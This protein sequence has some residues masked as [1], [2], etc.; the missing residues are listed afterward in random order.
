[1]EERL[2]LE[3]QRLFVNTCWVMLRDPDAIPVPSH[4]TA[5]CS[6]ERL[7]HR[8]GVKGHIVWEDSIV[9]CQ[10]ERVEVGR[11]VNA[12]SAQE[13]TCLGGGGIQAV[14]IHETLAGTLW[15]TACDPNSA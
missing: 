10:S 8:H 5:D 1:M 6:T 9:L 12:I 11:L 13:L 14:N 4:S 15:K 3:D 7:E 2:R